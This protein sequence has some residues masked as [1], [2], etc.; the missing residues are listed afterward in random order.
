MDK[1]GKTTS[2]GFHFSLQERDFA[3]YFT[4]TGME[5]VCSDIDSTNSE[6]VRE[7]GVVSPNLR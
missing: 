1:C 2:S 7:S 3:V 5:L 4:S 6:T